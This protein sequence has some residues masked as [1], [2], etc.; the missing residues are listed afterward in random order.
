MYRIS[1]W[2]MILS[3]LLK[4]IWYGPPVISKAEEICTGTASVE[5][6]AVSNGKLISS[7]LTS[8]PCIA[9]KYR[10]TYLTPSRTQGFIERVLKDV[11]VYSP[12]FEIDVEGVKIPVIAKSKGEFD[13]DEHLKLQSAGFRGFKA[14]EVLIR[15]GNRVRITGKITKNEDKFLLISKKIELLPDSPSSLTFRRKSGKKKKNR[16]EK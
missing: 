14:N 15:H 13:R 7:P 5:G 11:E 4:R 12:E 6:K 16:M 8:T 9:Y 10:A 1:M 3:K 2:N